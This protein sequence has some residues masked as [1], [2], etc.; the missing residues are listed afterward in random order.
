MP[1]DFHVLASFAFYKYAARIKK[2]L[3]EII[4]L[5]SNQNLLYT[6]NRF[7]Y[8]LSFFFFVSSIY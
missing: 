3:G 2:S 6:G 4:T 7:I 8:T 5:G 1:N